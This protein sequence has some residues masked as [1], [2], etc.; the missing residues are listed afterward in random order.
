MNNI[1]IVK[2]S[3]L[4]AKI[5]MRKT[6][7]IEVGDSGTESRVVIRDPGNAE[8]ALELSN[9]QRQEECVTAGQQMAHMLCWATKDNPGEGSEDKTS[10][11]LVLAPPNI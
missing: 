1:S 3:F 7:Y 4:Y 9:G 6:C 5:L 11:S 8:A 10:R 2:L